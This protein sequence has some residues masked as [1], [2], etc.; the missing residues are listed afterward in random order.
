MY[1]FTVITIRNFKFLAR[2][3]LKIIKLI[4]II[5]NVFKISSAH[6]IL[7]YLKAL[8]TILNENLHIKKTNSIT[9]IEI[10]QKYMVSYTM[11]CRREISCTPLCSGTDVTY[12][13]FQ[14]RLSNR[15]LPT[16]FLKSIR[17]FQTLQIKKIKNKK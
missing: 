4:Y 9:E 3:I 7:W 12:N 16:S 2:K 8:K 13:L 15:I 1:V 6:F 11:V 5:Q 14:S 17:Y 10:L